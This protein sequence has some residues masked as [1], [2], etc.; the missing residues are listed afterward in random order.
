MTQTLAEL[1]RAAGLTQTEAASRIG[2]AQ[3]SVAN[4]ESGRANPT[5]TNIME[6]ARVYGV[7]PTLVLRACLETGGANE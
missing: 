7:E 6:I 3:P 5:I 4:W 1:R 2:V